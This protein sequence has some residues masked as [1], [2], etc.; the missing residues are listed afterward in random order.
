MKQDDPATRHATAELIDKLSQGVAFMPHGELVAQ[1]VLHFIRKV[2]AQYRNMTQWPIH[3][4]IWTRTI[5][6]LPD[7]IPT[8]EDEIPQEDQLLVQK[9]WEDFHFFVPL[10]G[11]MYS[12]CLVRRLVLGWIETVGRK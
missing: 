5:S 7:R 1:E 8:W 2:S 3:E 9:N 10:A 4:C 12:G 6:F 11:I